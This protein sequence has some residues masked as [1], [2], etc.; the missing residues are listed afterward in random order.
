[1]ENAEGE[2]FSKAGGE[3]ESAN[4]II[5]TLK[6]GQLDLDAQLHAQEQAQAAA[7][8]ALMRNQLEPASLY[9][10]WCEWESFSKHTRV[11]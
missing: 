9:T 1:M 8:I 10:S 11:E 5:Q 2:L 3:F 7:F 6:A 4:H